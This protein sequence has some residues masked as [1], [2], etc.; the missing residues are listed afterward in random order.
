MIHLAGYA[1]RLRGR[2]DRAYGGTTGSIDT[3]LREDAPRFVVVDYKTNWL[4][5]PGGEVWH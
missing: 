4:A 3:V 2:L 1:G 5:V